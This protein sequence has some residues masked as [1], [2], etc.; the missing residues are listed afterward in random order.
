MKKNLKPVPANQKGLK[1]LPTSV[2]NNMG[3]L[4]KGSF[5]TKMTME[6]AEKIV[7]DKNKFK[8]YTPEEIKKARN[9]MM[10]D[11]TGPLLEKDMVNVG[12]KF[13]SPPK[14]KPKTPD[15]PKSKPKMMYGGMANKKKH[16]YAGG[17]SVQDKLGVMIAVGKIK[18]RSKNGK[19]S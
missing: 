1:E 12:G 17:G 8:N 3:Y 10:Q 13:I 11:A 19:S 14:K 9:M 4:N 6:D 16:S 7:S 18:P 5:I 15:V 2:R